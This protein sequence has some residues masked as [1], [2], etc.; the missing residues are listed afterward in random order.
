MKLEFI[1]LER[2]CI[3]KA[4]MRWSKKA[5]DIS[6][7]LP[8]VRKRGVIQPV[9]VRLCATAAGEAENGAPEYEIVAGSRRFH[10]ARA[11]W[12]EKRTAGDADAECAAL[13]CAILDEGDDADAI[14]ASLIENAARRDPAEVAQWE[15]FTRLVKE[16]RSVEDIAATFGLPDIAVRRVLALGNLL[17]RIRQ[18]YDREEI[19]RATVRHLTLASKSQQRAWLALFDDEDAYAPVGHQLKAWLF[20]GQSIPVRH[21]LF[22]QQASG[23]VIISDLFGEDAYFADA[24]AFWDAQNAELDTRREAWL[25][26]GWSDVVIV[27]V[28]EHFSVWEYEKAPKRKGGRV[29]V[30]LRA[31][32]EAVIHEGYLSRKEARQRASGQSEAE[33]P[34]IVRPELTS[35]LNIYVDLHRHAAVRAALLD[36]PDTALRLMLAHVVAGSSLWSIRPEPQTARNEEVAHSLAASRGEAL[37]SERR[38]AVLALLGAEPDEPHL[39]GGDDVPALVTLFHRMLDL[40]DAALMDIVGVVMGEC[41]ASG[42]AAVEAVGLVLGVDMGQWWEGDDAFLEL[43]R[44]REL[45][46]ALLADVAGEGVAAANAREKAKTQRRILGDHLRGENGR[47][48]RVG[49]VPRWMAFP[50]SAYTARGGVGTVRAHEA[51]CAAANAAQDGEDDPVP[52]QG[53]AAL[54]DPDGRDETGQQISQQEQRLAA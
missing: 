5:P 2:L 48:A 24:A 12:Q 25:D 51:A 33:R 14:E 19:D 44:D 3:S 41:L 8:T 23:L 34:K 6:D 43:L 47:Q 11:V 20:G 28:T 53:G 35:A 36:R 17:P 4:N 32:G 42:G 54:P 22:D 27:P 37:F 7:I 18:L 15:A 45:L 50:P 1:A 46:G 49:W 38:R 30:D 26:A 39:V 29:Y 9:I 21:A 52:P 40:P 13:P 16:G 31:N 10:A